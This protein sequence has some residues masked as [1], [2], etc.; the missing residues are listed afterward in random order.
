MCSRRFES[1]FFLDSFSVVWRRHVDMWTELDTNERRVVCAQRC[2][3][4]RFG[5]FLYTAT[6][7]D[8]FSR[9]W[10]PL[11]PRWVFL[12]WRQGKVKRERLKLLDLKTYCQFCSHKRKTVLLV[13][14]DAGL[15]RKNVI[16]RRL[17]TC[18]SI[19]AHEQEVPWP[20]QEA[21]TPNI[22]PP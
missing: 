10:V 16:K 11:L 22:P 18:H 8:R 9:G 6:D 7:S 4:R 1:W 21:F 20:N 5:G 3:R 2:L 17:C 19:S 12:R 14:S 15:E 13:Q